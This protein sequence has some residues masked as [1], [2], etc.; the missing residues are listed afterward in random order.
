MA[1]TLPEGG[2]LISLEVNP[3]HAKV[4]L[5][6]RL[7]LIPLTDPAQISEENIAHAGLSSKAKVLLGPAL[8][9]LPTLSPSPPFDLVFI[10]ADKDNNGPYFQHA[11]KL[12]RTGGVIIVD[13]V[14][15]N[16]RV[17]NPEITTSDILGIRKLLQIIKEDK[18]V[19]ATTIA[20]V[21]DKGYDGFTYILVRE[22]I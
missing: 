4:R 13:N 2:E 20:T 7:L 6:L 10:D 8:E 11:R 15:R 16:G 17:A 22:G 21:G 9:T 1:K 3:K 12:V 19:E 5:S 18:G 14:V